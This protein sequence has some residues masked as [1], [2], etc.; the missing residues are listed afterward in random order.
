[1]EF[2]PHEYQKYAIEWIIKKPS[3]ALFLDMGLGKTAC[4]LGALSDLMHNSYEIKKALVIG[5]FRVARDTWCKEK[6]KWDQ[7]RYFKV[8]KVMGSEK[9]R[10]AALDEKADF[11]VINRENVPWLVYYLGDRW[12]FDMVVIDELSSFK[13]PNSKR[14]RA[15]IRVRHRIKRI[16]GLTGTPAPNGL[17]DLWAQIFLLDEGQRLGRNMGDYVRKYFFPDRVYKGRVVKWKP[18]KGAEKMITDNLKDICMSMSGEDYLRLPKRFNNSI[19]VDMPAAARVKYMKFEEELSISLDGREIKAA[20]PAVLTG[21]LL[22]MANGAIYDEDRGVRH[23]HDVKLEALDE[24]IEA[25][26]GRPIL[27]YYNFRHDLER[28]IKHLRGTNFRVLDTSQDVEDWNNGD[29]SVMLAHPKSA[30]HGLNLQY[31]G[32]IIVWFGLTWSLEEYQQANARLHRQGQANYVTVNHII[33]RG[34]IDEDVMGVLQKKGACQEDI[35]EAVKARLKKNNSWRVK[36][37]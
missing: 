36:E 33:A 17:Y 12:D 30:G 21:K 15:L 22:Q 16:V 23:I 28:L 9:K 18:I 34:T 11:Y 31:G 5:T 4:T 8:S 24:I 25:S 6:D 10:I 7:F 19:M 20:N 29:I 26:N 32:S 13:N 35:L 14:F 1:M 2:K 27:V 3:A 37:G